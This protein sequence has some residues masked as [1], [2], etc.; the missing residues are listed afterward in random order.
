MDDIIFIHLYK[1]LLEKHKIKHLDC[2]YLYNF[3]KEI[4]QDGQSSSMFGSDEEI[5]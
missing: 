1:T 4:Y 3:A 5:I 2:E